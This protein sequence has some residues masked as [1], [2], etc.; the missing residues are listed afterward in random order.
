MLTQ[1]IVVTE[2]AELKA[3]SIKWKKIYTGRKYD[4]SRR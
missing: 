2:K 1:T 4:P 3:K